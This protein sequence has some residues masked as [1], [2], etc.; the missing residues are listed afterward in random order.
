MTELQII[1]AKSDPAAKA[2]SS[3]ST[4]DIQPFASVYSL[5]YDN[6]PPP[7]KFA[8]LEH[9]FWLLDDSFIPMPVNLNSL[10]WGWF[11]Q[12]M[13]GADGY[14]LN[15]PTLTIS[16]TGPH[17]SPGITLY[18][19]PDTNDFAELIRVTWY[20]SSNNILKAN[21]YTMNNVAA[22]VKEEIIDY[23]KIKIELLKTNNPYRY[24]KIFAIDFGVVYVISNDMINETEILEEIDPISDV[25]KINT[26]RFNLLHKNPEFARSGAPEKELLMKKQ[27][28][29]LLKDNNLFG[30][31]FLDTWNN[32][33][34]T[35]M[36]FDFK[37][38][39]A[40][41]IMEGYKFMGDMYN[42]T[43]AETIISQLFEICFPTHNIVYSLDPVLSSETITGYMPIMNCREALQW[44]C[45]AIG[46]IADT[47]RRDYIWIYARDIETEYF[48]PARDVYMEGDIET[49]EYISGVDVTAHNHTPIYETIELFKGDLPVGLRRIEFDEPAHTLI[50][51]GGIISES[52]ANYA[53]VKVM[54][55]GEIILIGKQYRNDKLIY[56][57]RDPYITAGESENIE[58]FSKCTIVNSEN[59]QKIAE[60][61][62][63]Y[64]KFMTQANIEIS[65]DDK[66][67]GYIAD[68]LL[69][70]GNAINGIIKNIK[71]DNV[72]ANRANI[73]QVGKYLPN[74]FCVNTLPMREANYIWLDDAVW[75]DNKFW[76][77]GIWS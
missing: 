68:T 25:L 45:F 73:Q 19:Y 33:D 2:D 35:N 17:K 5:R 24:T 23:Y 26:F 41:Q 13:S 36:E 50:I 22:A 10:T 12:S 64:Y 43:P 62:L 42:N 29:T 52:N 47:S 34:L 4:T 1:F 57:A 11:S 16:F 70:N 60:N 32:A 53:I 7:E 30:V 37:C 28:T 51:T 74:L 54:V 69:L 56:E 61:I 46:A 38:V 49:L 3:L 18:F 63:D 15:P 20:G 48:I 9:N 67:V 31:F 55:P 72:R 6:I 21:I 66:E 39:D 71:I 44:I 59:A 14:F 8:T 27:K 76:I 65:L 58:S 40:V 75:D 77:D